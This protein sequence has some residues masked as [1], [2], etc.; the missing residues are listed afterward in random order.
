[1][2]P[3]SAPG[4]RYVLER[5]RDIAHRRGKLLG[6]EAQFERKAVKAAAPD[7]GVQLDLLTK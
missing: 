5:I 6:N 3:L 7:F 4:V 2:S 1:M